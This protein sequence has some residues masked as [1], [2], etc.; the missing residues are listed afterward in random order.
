MGDGTSIG[1]VRGLGAAKEGAH[2]WWHQR[3]T[4]GGNLLLVLW[5]ILS[6]ARLPGYDRATLTAWIA[7]SWVAIPLILL[8]CSVFYHFRL[9][10]Q[11]CIE[12][13]SHG[14]G[15]IAWI[16]LLNAF[17]IVAAGVA[18]FSILSIAFTGAAA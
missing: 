17:T 10:L 5:F 18:I 13:Y 14:P 16:V 8:V 15:R 12:D 1:R 7:S 3:L 9:G 4:A 6:I 11:V 2:H